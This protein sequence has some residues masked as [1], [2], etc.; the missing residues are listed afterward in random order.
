MG[1]DGE[2]PA[3]WP[4]HDC[5]IEEDLAVRPVLGADIARYGSDES[6]IYSNRG[7]R[8]R[9][10]DSWG[11]ADTVETA[12]RIHRHAINLHAAEVRIDAAGVGGGV[13]DMLRNLEEFYPRT[14]NLVGIDGARRAPD[15]RRWANSRAH[16]HEQLRDAMLE[17]RLDL[18]FSDRDLT[19]QLTN[20]TF[21]FA[22]SGGV[23]I[24]P[25][26]EMR[27]EMDGSPDRLDALIYSVLDSSELFLPPGTVQ[28]GD[29]V[30]LDPWEMLSMSRMDADYPL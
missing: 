19:D 29:T 15:P 18:D 20:T 10:L 23:Q 13:Y 9:L 8:A 24:T 12:R 21:R 5:N 16:N 14:Y 11:K 25:K 7:G 2:P 27:T 22:K 28:P 1:R 6:V 3:W 30:M 4:A 17:G 26:D